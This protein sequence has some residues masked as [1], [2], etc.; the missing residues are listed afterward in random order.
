MTRI[1]AVVFD[2]DDTLFPEREYAFSGYRAV[3]SAFA[4]E[5]G[6][7]VETVADL[8]RLFDS[9]HRSRVFDALLNERFGT[10]DQ[11]LAARMI[12]TFREHSPVITP[13]A[14]VE[15][16]LLRLR[17]RFKLGLLTDGR[18]SVQWGKIDALRLRPR[19]DAIIVTDELRTG[20]DPCVSFGKPHPQAFKEMA[21][22][23]GAPNRACA[24]VADN[25]TKDFVAPNMLGWLSVR[26]IRP[27]AVYA[28][29]A[30]AENG[31]ARHTVMNFDELDLVLEAAS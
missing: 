14:D 27:D 6:D 10:V 28:T 25:V 15:A 24:Y 12:Q 4:A 30:C 22:K 19:F 13:Y 21:A 7:A 20:G 5:L 8:Q 3:A 16:A 11:A 18:A 17:G 2:L 1:Q 31:E 26:I 9:A 23:L 29:A